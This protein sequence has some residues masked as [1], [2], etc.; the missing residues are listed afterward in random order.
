M[1]NKKFVLL[2]LLTLMLAGCWDSREPERMLYVNALGVDFKDDKYEVYAQLISFANIAK[3]E[4]PTT[5]QPQAEVGF[6][7]GKSLD[8]AL[9]NLYHSI[10][11]R[12]FWGHFSYLIISEDAMKS[13]KFNPVIDNLVRYRETRYQIWVYVTKDPV[14]DLLL[15]KPILNKALTLSKLG[16]PEDSY[17][18][19]SYIKP[20][21]FREL[22]I[23]MDEPGH[24]A[25]IPLINIE[26]NWESMQELIEAPVLSGVGVV[27]AN[28]FKGFIEG[29]KAKGIQWMTNETKR[30]QITFK[31][32]DD[33]HTTTIIDHVKVNIQPIV[34]SG[35][36]RFDVAVDLEAT[37]GIIEGKMTAHEIEKG[38]KKEAEKE[39]I[40]TYEE[41]LKMDVDIYRFSEQ[42][43]RKNIKAW[44]KHQKDGKIELNKDSIRN[45]TVHISKLKSSRKS[46]KETIEKK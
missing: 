39:I 3:S 45:L 7:S 16:N 27:T 43:Y 33:T 25:L 24:E 37:V 2:L 36:V 34:E 23:G 4:Q 40:A 17:K 19:E 42:L 29:D 9:F 31:T 1:D 21:N 32:N 12:V 28:G 8:E 30:G 38:V 35:T 44:K 20:V 13:V 15:V 6:A 41:A 5:D 22:I 46:Y 18:Q 10:D 26:A 14:Q 11:Q